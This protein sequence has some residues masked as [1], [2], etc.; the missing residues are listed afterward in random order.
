M[1]RIVLLPVLLLALLLVSFVG[2]FI[3]YS[4]ARTQKSTVTNCTSGCY[5]WFAWDGTTYGGYS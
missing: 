3:P 2:N 1:K 4:Y 5:A